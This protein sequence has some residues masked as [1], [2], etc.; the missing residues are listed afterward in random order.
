MI[1]HPTIAC[2]DVSLSE[3][4]I[5]IIDANKNPI[6]GRCLKNPS[7]AKKKSIRV[8]ESDHMRVK[9]ITIVLRDLFDKY[10]YRAI[11][12]EIPSGGTQRASSATALG[13]AK[14]AVWSFAEANYLPVENYLPTDCKQAVTGHKDASKADVQ[15]AVKDR[16][17]DFEWPKT[18]YVLEAVCD[19]ASAFY[20][21]EK[22]GNLVRMLCNG[23]SI[24][25][26]N[27]G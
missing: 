10:N 5:L 17:K 20:A 22:H 23:P 4:G 7:Q 6:E 2:L 12:A 1:A 21:A 19:A 26:D 18:K 14:G 13:H 8:L 24:I 16:W 15:K 27:R 9:E 3:P 11:V 25:T